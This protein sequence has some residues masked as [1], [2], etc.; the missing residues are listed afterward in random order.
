MAHSYIEAWPG[1]LARASLVLMIKMR[2]LGNCS[3]RPK[4]GNDCRRGVTSSVE[5]S[6]ANTR[7][8]HLARAKELICCVAA[9]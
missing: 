9:G 8:I 5:G 7:I 4:F 1:C 2:K 3:D 6:F